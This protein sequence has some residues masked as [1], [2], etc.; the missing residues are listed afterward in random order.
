MENI[1]C[2]FTTTSFQQIV[3]HVCLRPTLNVKVD[4]EAAHTALPVGKYTLQRDCTCSAKCVHLYRLCVK[5]VLSQAVSSLSLW[6]GEWFAA[7]IW[8]MNKCFS[9]C[10]AGTGWGT[11]TDNISNRLG[12]ILWNSLNKLLCPLF[13]WSGYEYSYDLSFWYLEWVFLQGKLPKIILY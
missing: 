8:E 3:S 13:L 5:C 10:C 9:G 12:L 6:E 2:T 4:S 7:A 11:H 1:F